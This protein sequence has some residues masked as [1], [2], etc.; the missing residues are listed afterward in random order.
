M[1]LLNINKIS[2]SF[3]QGSS[4]I[5]VLNDFSLEVQRNEVLG[6]VGESG[7]GKSTLLAL[8]AGLDRPDSGEILF[9]G[10]DIS[11]LPEKDL[12]VFRAQNIGIVFQQFHLLPHLTAQ[13]NVQLPLEI[14]NRESEA[15]RAD[16]I[17]NVLGMG[18]RL[19]HYPSQLSGGEAQR[20]AL[21]RALVVKPKILLADE[22]TGSLDPVTGGKII[23]FFFTA[24]K[25]FHTTA[26]L[27]THNIEF[28]K[29]CDR[30]VSLS[31]RLS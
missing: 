27:V 1:S 15:H 7:S 30:S 16:E 29:R 2:K 6:I 19:K 24:C 21:A 25:E 4:R 28:A 22:P 18:H 11:Q 14:L 9:E 31:Q 10:R 17:L 5:Q 13:E 3:L 12:T 20:V 26:V 8:M 23:E